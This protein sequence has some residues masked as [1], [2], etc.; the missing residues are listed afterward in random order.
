[1]CVPNWPKNWEY[2]EKHRKAKLDE[3]RTSETTKWTKPKNSHAQYNPEIY[4]SDAVVMAAELDCVETGKCYKA[5]G[6]RKTL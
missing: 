1:M 4:V 6:R 3:W 2:R 5:T